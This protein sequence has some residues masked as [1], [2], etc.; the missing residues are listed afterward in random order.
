LNGLANYSKWGKA[1]ENAIPTPEHYLPLLYAI[2][3]REE[4]DNLSFFNDE[5]LA[6]AISMTSVMIGG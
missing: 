6:G 4:E 1:F 3:L 2:G 5:Y